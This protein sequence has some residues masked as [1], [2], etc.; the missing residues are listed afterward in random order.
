LLKVR[1]KVLSTELGT[2]LRRWLP[3]FLVPES[4]TTGELAA[5]P[6]LLLFTLLVRPAIGDHFAQGECGIDDP[7]ADFDPQQVVA[8]AEASGGE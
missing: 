2:V 6:A 5:W 4:A 3:A 1:A 7:D 8:V